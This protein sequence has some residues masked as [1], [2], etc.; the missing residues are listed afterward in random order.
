MIAGDG[1][2]EEDIRRRIGLAA[3]AFGHLTTIWKSKDVTIQTDKVLVYNTLV[4]PIMLYGAEC[5]SLRKSDEKKILVVEMSW[6]RRILGVSRLQRIRND[7][8]RKRLGQEISLVHKIQERRL[9]WFGHVS[10]MSPERLPYLALH[11]KIHGSRKAGR[12]RRRWIDNVAEDLDQRGVSMNSASRLT[13]NREAWRDI[14]RPHR[15]S[16]S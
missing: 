2:C 15:H 4:V 16:S 13:L 11:T 9:K 6:L 8:I 1:N 10:R 5:W 12:P 7:A 14:T 3:G